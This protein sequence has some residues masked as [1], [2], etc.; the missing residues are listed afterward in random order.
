LKFY[1]GTRDD[2]EAPH[3]FPP[4]GDP[5]YYWD[6]ELRKTPITG[7]TLPRWLSRFDATQEARDALRHIEIAA[8]A[9][10]SSAD[11]LKELKLTVQGILV[12]LSLYKTW[13]EAG[14]R[15]RILDT[16]EEPEA[17]VEQQSIIR[18]LERCLS[19][20]YLQLTLPTC[21]A[22]NWQRWGQRFFRTEVIRIIREKSLEITG[23]KDSGLSASL[24]PLTNTLP[25]SIGW[26]PDRR[27]EFGDRFLPVAIDRCANRNA[28]LPVEDVPPGFYTDPHID[29]SAPKPTF[30]DMPRG[31]QVFCGVPFE[32]TGDGSYFT[33]LD[34]LGEM[35]DNSV[36]ELAIPSGKEHSRIAGIHILAAALGRE[37][38]GETIAELVLVSDNGTLHPLPIRYRRQVTNFRFPEVTSDAR[39]GWIQYADDPRVY[40]QHAVIGF[41]CAGLE[42]PSPIAASRIQLRQTSSRAGLMLFAVTAEAGS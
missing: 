30:A 8:E 33:S 6:D 40:H 26:E 15:S 2:L 38:P 39:V 22:L 4:R 27:A 11:S 41:C 13:A 9:A 25:L 29:P 36:V 19:Y 37:L 35:G 21:S 31:S 28:D 32:M 20:G 3:G 17:A 1:E 18:L 16:L 23:T 5:Y 12:N 34:P 10:G 24:L 42:L 7:E 14:L